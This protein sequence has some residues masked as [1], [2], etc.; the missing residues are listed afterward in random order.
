MII[1]EGGGQMSRPTDQSFVLMAEIHPSAA[2]CHNFT[3][4]YCNFT[5]GRQRTGHCRATSRGPMKP[6]P[7]TTRSWLT[8]VSLEPDLVFYCLCLM[9]IAKLKQN[10]DLTI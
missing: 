9:F 7:T 4:E 6:S 3:I 1:A 8:R 10:A 5:L 2:E